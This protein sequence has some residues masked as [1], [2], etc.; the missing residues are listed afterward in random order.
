MPRERHRERRRLRVVGSTVRA[1]ARLEL[2]GPRVPAG[3][4]LS[5]AEAVAVAAAAAAR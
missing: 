2:A 1:L 5:R 4:V 3:Q